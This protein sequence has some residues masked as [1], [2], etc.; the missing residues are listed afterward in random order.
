MLVFFNA[1]L[2]MLN[3][4]SALCG[5]TTVNSVSR[6]RVIE[7]HRLP[8][9]SRMDST[10]SSTECSI[11]DSNGRG[12]YPTNKIAGFEDHVKVRPSCALKFCVIASNN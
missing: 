9:A 6:D 8:Q 10:M 7:L 12:T 1:L 11:D 2:A 4:R 3:A 5:A